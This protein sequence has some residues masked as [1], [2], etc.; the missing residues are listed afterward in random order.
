MGWFADIL[1]TIC[2]FL[3]QIIYQFI[4]TVYDFITVLARVEIFG[5]DLLLELANNIYSL[6]AIFMVFKLSFSVFTAIVNPEMLADKK[7]GFVTIL[8]RSVIAIGLIAVLPMAFSFAWRVQSIILD[9]GIVTK[10]VIGKDLAETGAGGEI[11]KATLNAFI[12]CGETCENSSMVVEGM[13][14]KEI[15]ADALSNPKDLSAMALHINDGAEE[16]YFY[17]YTPVISGVVGIAILYLLV[18]FCFDIALRTVQLGFLQLVSPVIVISY[19]DPKS[20]EDGF[21]KKYMTLFFSTYLT[22]FIRLL[23]LSF[24]ALAVS[25]FPVIMKDLVENTIPKV[26]VGKTEG[27]ATVY[28][29]FILIFVIIGLLMFAKKAPDMICDLFGVKPN[30]QLDIRKIA[31]GIPGFGLA[32]GATSLATSGIG[33]GAAALGAGF[34]GVAKGLAHGAGWKN[35]WAGFGER[36]KAGA[37]NVPMKGSFGKKIVGIVGASHKVNADMGTKL[38]A[39]KSATSKMDIGRSYS[40]KISPPSAPPKTPKNYKS[41]YS[42]QFAEKLEKKD[43]AKQ[44]WIDA[45]KE[46]TR[47]TAAYEHS[48]SADDLEKLKTAQGAE[49]KA[50]TIKDAYNTDVKDWVSNPA[51]K[52]DAE[53]FEAVSYYEDRPLSANTPAPAATSNAETPAPTGTATETPAPTANTPTSNPEVE[54]TT[55]TNGTKTKSGILLSGKEYDDIN[56]R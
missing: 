29:A 26:L 53:V 24:L 52:K 27:E 49:F 4:P 56:H 25:R 48:R 35:S 37:K 13:T 55:D 11:A 28:A 44:N 12:V 30:F 19:A 38:K 32:T 20:T 54:T 46:V 17:D 50:N 7:K 6:L 21:V 18:V 51:N 40:N 8:M 2:F 39:Q 23:V 31:K 3:D 36:A 10:V 15:L 1:R 34:G 42:S 33:K 41:V 47:L 22:L 45:K 43:L 9:K 14:P 16:K 5:N